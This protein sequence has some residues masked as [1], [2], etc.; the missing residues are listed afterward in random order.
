[1]FYLSLYLQHLTYDFA[2]NNPRKIHHAS[3]KAGG[4]T[5]SQSY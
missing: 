3:A 1:M 4:N 5:G 2:E